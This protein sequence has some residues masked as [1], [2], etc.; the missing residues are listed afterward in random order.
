MNL[1]SDSV[2][3]VLDDN[4]ETW[5]LIVLR[6]DGSE[7]LVC[8]TDSGLLLPSVQIPAH[9]RTAKSLNARLSALWNLQVYSLYPIQLKDA[10]NTIRYH[11]VEILNGDAKALLPGHWIS[12]RDVCRTRFAK[13]SD[14]AA[15]QQWIENLAS[16]GA[17]ANH[18]PFRNPGWFFSLK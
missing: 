13:D 11:V 12:V 6:E 10:H 15:V 8:I 4:L 1:G 5:R 2:R 3:N 16:E 9:S 14:C 7:F 18:T 17:T